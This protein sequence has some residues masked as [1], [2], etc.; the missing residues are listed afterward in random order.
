LGST[1]SPASKTKRIATIKK[2][3][4]DLKAKDLADISAS[5]PFIS[6]YLCALTY[7]RGR[8]DCGQL[9][10]FGGGSKKKTL[11]FSRLHMWIHS[12]NL[13]PWRAGICSICLG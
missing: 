2:G 6:G 1:W 13:D 12:A 5:I 3:F 10:W 7:S 9:T 4:A 11:V 8:H